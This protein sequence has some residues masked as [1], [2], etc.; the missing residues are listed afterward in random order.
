MTPHSFG[1]KRHQHSAFVIIDFKIQSESQGSGSKA[2]EVVATKIHTVYCDLIDN[3]VQ[4]DMIERSHDSTAV[5]TFLFSINSLRFGTQCGETGEAGME[6]LYLPTCP[7]LSS[8]HRSPHVQPDLHDFHSPSGF[9]LNTDGTI[10]DYVFS[11]LIERVQ[12]SPANIPRGDSSLPKAAVSN[13][14]TSHSATASDIFAFLSL[15]K[16]V[17]YNLSP[18]S[19]VLSSELSPQ[20]N[21]H[22]Q[23]LDNLHLSSMR[24]CAELL[25]ECLSHMKEAELLTCTQVC[26]SW[27]E[28]A[29]SFDLETVDLRKDIRKLAELRE[30]P[31][32]IRYIRR[33]IGD[34]YRSFTHFDIPPMRVRALEFRGDLLLDTP[35]PAECT[36]EIILAFHRIVEVFTFRDSIPM[37]YSSFRTILISLGQCKQLR[38]LSL[39]PT[40]KSACGSRQKHADDAYHAFRQLALDL[41]NIEDRPQLQFLQLVSASGRDSPQ[42]ASTACAKGPQESEYKWLEEPNCPFNLHA[43]RVLVVGC[44]SAAQI[45]LPI[46]SHSLCK[47]ELC[48]AFD[49]RLSWTQYEHFLASPIQLSSLKHLVLTFHICP[50]KW[51]LDMIRAPAIE[52]IT[53]KWTTNTPHASYEEHFRLIDGLISRL[54]P[55]RVFPH[56]LT[57]IVT[58]TTCPSRPGGQWG[59]NVFPISSQFG[60]IVSHQRFTFTDHDY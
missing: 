26:R 57:Q 11:L 19:R 46:A 58:V 21:K 29:K 13:R 41:P 36:S 31:H 59:L 9:V 56:R 52:T 55:T 38:K 35:I 30:H 16:V 17:K 8:G 54:D 51:L 4:E 14:R 27:R 28:E 12:R 48:Q 42:V 44:P 23:R 45:V 18:L 47:L 1:L 60:V 37:L 53:F 25:S 10:P 32:R 40:D 5:R 2:L 39:P 3:L 50:S 24:L 22:L 20:R 15:F 33:I 34:P 49:P 6:C 43:L 7:S